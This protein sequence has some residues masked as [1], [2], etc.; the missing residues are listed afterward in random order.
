VGMVVISGA[1]NPGV[2]HAL[3]VLCKSTNVFRGIGMLYAFERLLVESVS[4]AFF[5]HL[6]LLRFDIQL[7]DT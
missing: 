3:L 2:G 1:N 4:S 7:T 6:S 5:N